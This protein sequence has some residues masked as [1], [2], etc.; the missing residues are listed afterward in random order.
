MAESFDSPRWC[1][2]P[3]WEN[4]LYHQVEPIWDFVLG[5]VEKLAGQVLFLSGAE[6]NLAG[7]LAGVDLI[8]LWVD[9]IY[10]NA[11]TQ[12]NASAI[13]EALEKQKNLQE[14]LILG[15][16]E[17]PGNPIAL[18]TIKAHHPIGGHFKILSGGELRYKTASISE[19]P[20]M[21][22]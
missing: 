19:L 9:G 3:V 7:Q 1:L 11:I 8:W 20:E 12:A 22:G 2:S 21:V 14:R 16:V 13:L 4:K 5:W 10:N 6:T 17:S 15:Y 18:R